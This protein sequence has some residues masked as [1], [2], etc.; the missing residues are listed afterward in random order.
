MAVKKLE[1][2]PIEALIPY[3]RNA[4]KHS[5]EQV[6]QIAASIREFGFNAPV[7]V[8]GQNG[9]IAGHGRVLAARKLGL[10]KVPCIRLAHLS[11]TQRRAYIIADNRLAETS[12]GWDEEMLKLEVKEID[13][14]ELNEISIDDF[15]FGELDFGTKQEEA[16][17]ANPYTAK[18]EAPIYKPTGERPELMELADQKK[19]QELLGQIEQSEVSE[20]EKEFLRTA[21]RRHI[22]FHYQK[23]AEYYAHADKEMQELMEASALVVIDFKKSIELGFTKLTE[24]I[25]SQ[26]AEDFED[27]A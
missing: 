15:K 19:F 14:A 23:V 9:I 11:E 18:V 17:E 2:V 26:M 16:G 12:G 3:A 20:Q 27:E 6:A 21:A 7:L 1:F 25:A 22:V 24:S 10:D 4:K 13:W 8:D 5:D